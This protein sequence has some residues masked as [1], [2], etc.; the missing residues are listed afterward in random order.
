MTTTFVKKLESFAQ[1][2][3]QCLT[4]L[5]MDFSSPSPWH[6][7]WSLPS[8]IRAQAFLPPKFSFENEQFRPFLVQI[9]LM[10]LHPDLKK[11]MSKQLLRDIQNSDF[12]ITPDVLD[13]FETG[14]AFSASHPPYTFRPSST[15]AILQQ[16]LL[17]ESLLPTKDTVEAKVATLR[18]VKAD[19]LDSW[20]ALLQTVFNIASFNPTL[21]PTV[22]FHAL[23]SGLHPSRVT[24]HSRILRM[25]GLSDTFLFQN[26]S[27]VS[28]AQLLDLVRD[29]EAEFT[30]ARAIATITSTPK[31]MPVLVDSSLLTLPITASSTSEPDRSLRDFMESTHS[32]L[33]DIKS[34]VGNL[35]TEMT[36]L[37][38]VQS[39]LVTD[40]SKRYNLVLTGEASRETGP[41]QPAA[42]PPPSDASSGASPTYQQPPYRGNLP[43]GSTRAPTPTMPAGPFSMP[44]TPTPTMPTGPFSPPTA[45]NPMRTTVSFSPETEGAHRT[46]SPSIPTT[47]VRDSGTPLPGTQSAS[48]PRYCYAFQRGECRR[49]SDCPYVH[50]TAPPGSLGRSRPAGPRRNPHIAGVCTS[51]LAGNCLAGAQCLFKHPGNLNTSMVL[52]LYELDSEIEDVCSGATPDP[53]LAYLEEETSG[54]PSS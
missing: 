12:E 42:P 48:Q 38:R 10:C 34:N 50:D 8:E 43:L 46:S 45:Q 2:A 1:R 44:R 31:A 6:W 40:A 28:Y 24:E 52:T 23:K 13:T 29:M 35:T 36:E 21:D 33:R 15:Q 30:H 22:M 3:A 32:S 51:F 19:D 11:R 5:N 49:G 41:F 18:T 16:G 47:P 20:K 4:C 14:F 53:G 37:R 27:A 39:N 17:K 54:M 26:G 25:R 7:C 9:L